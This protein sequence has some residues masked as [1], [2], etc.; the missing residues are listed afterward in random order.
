MSDD[1]FNANSDH[2][3]LYDPPPPGTRRAKQQPFYE[4]G[5]RY[6]TA[7][8]IAEFVAK[9]FPETAK[10]SRRAAMITATCNA[11]GSAHER[12]PKSFALVM[13]PTECLLICDTC[14]G[15]S[16]SDSELIETCRERAA[17]SE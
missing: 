6:V 10:K 5:N 7:D 1:R 8:E 4:D 15:Q 9:Q 12:T 2:P 16:T 3:Y 14:F 13:S 17:L 11:C